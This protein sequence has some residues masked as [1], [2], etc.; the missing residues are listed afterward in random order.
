ML[1]S[2]LHKSVI[3]SAVEGPATLSAPAHCSNLSINN[4]ASAVLLLSFFYSR[5]ESAVAVAFVVG[6]ALAFS[7]F[8][9]RRESAFA[10]AVVCSHRS[11]NP[12][13]HSSS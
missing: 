13:K 2:N 11:P 8:H 3:L 1:S 7:F 10:L 6:L 9:S 5:R 12:H 4:L